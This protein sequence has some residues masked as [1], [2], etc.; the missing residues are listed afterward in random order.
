MLELAIGMTNRQD[1]ARRFLDDSLGYAAHQDVGQS[2]A[3]VGAEHDQVGDLALR[4]VQDFE[5][6]RAD[7]EQALYL[8]PG[9]AEITVYLVEFLLREHAL[10]FGDSANRANVHR[11]SEFRRH[12]DRRERL[13][14]V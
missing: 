11:R 9:G 1:R 3:A 2:G 6:R 14:D 7:L 8:E 12:H 10:L 5:E 13:L 4:G